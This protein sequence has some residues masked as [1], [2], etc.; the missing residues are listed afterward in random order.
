[1]EVLADVFQ[2]RDGYMVANDLPTMLDKLLP[3]DVGEAEVEWISMLAEGVT[4]EVHRRD[5]AFALMSWHGYR[6]MVRNFVHLFSPF[7]VKASNTFSDEDAEAIMMELNGGIPV[8]PLEARRVSDL[9]DQMDRGTVRR[10]DIMAAIGTW[11]MDSD[12]APMKP[13]VQMQTGLAF[14]GSQ[15]MKIVDQYSRAL[16]PI[17]AA[18]VIAAGVLWD[19]PCTSHLD[20]L[21]VIQAVIVIV[22]KYSPIVALAA[23]LVSLL[24]LRSVVDFSPD[25]EC[26]LGLVS[27]LVVLL[28]IP[29]PFLFTRIVFFVRLTVAYLAAVRDLQSPSGIPSLCR[30]RA[31]PYSGHSMSRSAS[32][33]SILRTPDMSPKSTTRNQHSGGPLSPDFCSSSTYRLLDTGSP[34]GT[35]GSTAG[36]RR[37]RGLH[38]PSEQ[39]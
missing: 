17:A 7:D 33:V 25:G 16:W 27:G 13:M 3:D 32:V 8:S 22:Q 6:L 35:A 9:A 1:V 2:G 29:L 18:Q 21:L 11:Y 30:Q 15:V 14:A 20:A 28:L 38:P 31:S 37:E 4:G 19:R 36:C 12:A 23:L 39:V 10:F 26:G 34:S 5:I 24:A